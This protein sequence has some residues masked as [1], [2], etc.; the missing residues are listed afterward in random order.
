LEILNRLDEVSFNAVLLRELRMIVLLRQ[1]ADPGDM[2]GASWTHAGDLGH[3][4]SFNLD[5]L[6]SSV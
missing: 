6:P 3:P 2:E 5:A 1:V 4:S